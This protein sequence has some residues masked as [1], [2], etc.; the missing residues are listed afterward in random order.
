MTCH[1]GGIPG[2]WNGTTNKPTRW[3][4]VFPKKLRTRHF[5]EIGSF[6]VQSSEF[7][8]GRH[9]PLAWEVCRSRDLLSRSSSS[10]LGVG[11]SVSSILS[12]KV[13]DGESGRMM[14]NNV[15]RFS[16]S[17]NHDVSSFGLI[18]C[19]WKPVVCQ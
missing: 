7:A 19:L 15:I 16:V 9:E 11:Y 1:R 6:E 18:F 8:V 12:W 2:I 5:S 13:S 3:Q 10:R 14:D 17:K 4:G